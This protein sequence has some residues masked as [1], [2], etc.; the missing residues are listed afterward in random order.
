MSARPGS[1]GACT[2]A[3][4]L[5]AIGAGLTP[6]GSA[7]DE[8]SETV[9]GAPSLGEAAGDALAAGAAGDALAAGDAEASGDADAAGDALA[10][11][12]AEDA[13]FGSTLGIVAGVPAT[14]Q[15]LISELL[16]THTGV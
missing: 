14:A 2:A 3:T 15:P 6:C 5:G 13:A 9:P 10:A 12:D 16:V 4:S 8:A 7:A 11:G 1:T